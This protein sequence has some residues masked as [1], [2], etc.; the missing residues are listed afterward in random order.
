MAKKHYQN[1][2]RLNF[3]IETEEALDNLTKYPE[4]IQEIE[5]ESRMYQTV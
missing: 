3:L 5:K 4:T 2:S 1:I